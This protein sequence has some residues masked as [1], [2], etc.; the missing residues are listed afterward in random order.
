MDLNEAMDYAR[1]GG[2]IGPHADEALRLL[3]AEVQSLRSVMAETAQFV[4]AAR[5][6]CELYED[7]LED[8]P[9]GGTRQALLAAYRALDGET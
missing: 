4:E 1:G 5:S 7:D 6:Y 9:E 3:A 2:P 8:G